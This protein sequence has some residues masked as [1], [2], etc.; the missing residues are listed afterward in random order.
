MKKSILFFL[1]ICNAS[2]F[3]SYAMLRAP[4][5][6]NGRIL[7]S[8]VYRA[9]KPSEMTITAA[10]SKLKLTDVSKVKSKNSSAKSDINPI[11][12][13]V[14]PYKTQKQNYYKLIKSLPWGKVAQK[15]IDLFAEHEKKLMQEFFKLTHMTPA[16]LEEYKSKIYKEF[17]EVEA[18]SQKYFEMLNIPI[19]KAIAQAIREMKKLYAFDFSRITWRIIKGKQSAMSAFQNFLHI[20]QEFNEGPADFLSIEA[21][22]VHEYQHLI[23]DD[24]F[25]LWCFEHYL[26]LKKVTNKD[27]QIFLKRFRIFCETRAD[28][29]GYMLDLAYINSQLIDCKASIS[30]DGVIDDQRHAAVDERIAYLE[31]LK[32]E[33]KAELLG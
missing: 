13:Y 24:N 6:K 1:V 7:L 25:I 33:I 10:Q 18:E 28:I 5:K 9:K 4:R 31:S 15:Y 17:L 12:K 32:A 26:K 23:H 29:L 11:P 16:K 8:D 22:L 19:H 20:G 14:N 21:T 30:N 3:F 2:T 27:A